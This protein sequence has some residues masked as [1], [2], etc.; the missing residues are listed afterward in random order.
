MNGSIQSAED[1]V[2]H[3]MRKFDHP[4]AGTW[5]RVNLD[6]K[7]NR[8]GWGTIRL[9][10]TDGKPLA[11]R[12]IRL[13]QKNH[14]FKFG[15]N[16]F[17]LKDFKE[18]EKNAA[19]EAYF[20]R[21]FNEAVVPL[22]WD[23]T[24]P[25]K[26]LFRYAKDS[27]HMDRR[28]PADLLVDWCEENGIA[29]KGHWLFCDNFVPRW[30]PTDNRKVMELLEDRIAGLAERYGRRIR[31]WDVLN[32]SFTYHPRKSTKIGDAAIPDDYVFQIFKMA[33]KYFPRMSEF[34]YNDGTGIC[35]EAFAHDSS[36]V[37]LLAERLR[38]RMAKLDGIGM[39]FHLY[40][41]S[42]LDHAKME[43][44]SY[45]DPAHILNV[46]DQMGKLNL[47]IH[48]SEISLTTYSDL[49]RELAE[50]LQARLLRNF[51]TLWFSHRNCESIVFW[52][53]CDQTA[54]GNENHCNACLI[55]EKFE[56]KPSY[57]M[58]DRL[59]NKEWKTKTTIST[60][61]NGEASWNGFYGD[62]EMTAGSFHTELSLNP[63]SEN[64]YK[65]QLS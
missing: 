36:P 50:E 10:G 46:L 41:D 1:K 42:I 53:L 44:K 12:E 29:P 7:R 3:L 60:D 24:E 56:E 8:M 55:N 21:V 19:Y 32:E 51:Y 52:N 45:F 14:D 26:G 25:E 20:K 54:Y 13:E 33:E 28:P 27:V 48:I 64:E 38:S 49:P 5:E 59:V 16:A 6:I 39:Q 65:L 31:K 2:K 47:P 57:Q 23:S 30:L 62:Y 18:P 37:Y 35:F 43:Q 4:K 22:L 9:V 63:R 61:E 58:L 11:N 40:A 15:C 17:K 34:I